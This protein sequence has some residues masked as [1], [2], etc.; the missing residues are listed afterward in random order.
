MN[1]F[2]E[3]RIKNLQFQ[4]IRITFQDKPLKIMN[5]KNYKLQK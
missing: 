1:E 4:K 3:I 2:Q 5:S